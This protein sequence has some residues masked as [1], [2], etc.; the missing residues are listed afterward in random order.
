MKNFLL[1]GDAVQSLA[2]V[3]FQVRPPSLHLFLLSSKLTVFS[4]FARAGGPLQAR[5]SRSRLPPRL[6]LQRELPHQRRQ[7]RLHLWRRPRSSSSVRV[8]SVESVSSL[9]L[10]SRHHT[11]ATLFDLQTSPLTPVNAFSA[12]RSTSPA[13]SRPQR[14]SS[15]STFAEKTRSRTASSTVRLR[16]SCLSC[17]PSLTLF[18]RLSGGLDGSMSTLVPVRDAVFKRL[19]NVQTLMSRHVLQ[20]AGLSSRAHRCVVVPSFPVPSFP[21]FSSSSILIHSGSLLRLLSSTASS[22]T[23]PSVAPSNA[24]SSTVTASPHSSTSPSISRRNLQR[25]RTRT[26]IRSGRT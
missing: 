22:R 2:L 7:G 12:G 24:V 25:R 21:P 15:R 16:I 14:C 1:I 10:S 4:I 26:R 13:P 19:Q 3:A 18:P 20:F 9:L 6:Y 17:Q 8:R 5:P 23:T 11:D